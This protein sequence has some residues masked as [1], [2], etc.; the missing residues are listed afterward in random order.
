MTEPIDN[1]QKFN[2]DI[3]PARTPCHARHNLVGGPE[4][5]HQHRPAA[6]LQSGR[7]MGSMFREQFLASLFFT[8]EKWP[9]KPVSFHK[10][11]AFIALISPYFSTT[12]M[13]F[14]GTLKCRKSFPD[15]D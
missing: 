5:R 8:E 12:I 13:T 2:R 9:A 14:P 10:K 4:F 6:N 3:F 11:P 7:R 1:S 15:N